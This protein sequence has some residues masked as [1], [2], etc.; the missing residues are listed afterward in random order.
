M[1]SIDDPVQHYDRVTRAWQYLLG[2]DFHFGYFRHES[3]SLEAATRNLTTLMAERGSF[4]RD[5]SVLDVGAASAI[6]R[7]F[8]PTSTGAG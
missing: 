5:M 1:S 4:G 8:L 6:R 7:A 2:E 3:E